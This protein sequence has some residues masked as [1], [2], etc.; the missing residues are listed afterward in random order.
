MRAQAHFGNASHCGI[1][2][3]GST[4][5]GDTVRHPSECQRQILRLLPALMPWEQLGLSKH[6]AGAEIADKSVQSYASCA[7]VP[8][9]LPMHPAL[10]SR[11]APRHQERRGFGV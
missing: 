2:P 4:D 1:G 8:A 7:T 11:Q 3:A 6:S 5:L 9:K 10:A